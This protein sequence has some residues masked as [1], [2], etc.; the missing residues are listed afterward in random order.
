M[1]NGRLRCLGS[2][3]HLKLTFGSGYEIDMK[4]QLATTG[5]L[6]S[7]ANNLARANVIKLA[8]PGAKSSDSPLLEQ[9]IDGDEL[10]VEEMLIN[11]LI[12]KQD[13]K[14]ICSA[15]LESERVEMIA[16]NREGA[17]LYTALEAD[18]AIPLKNFLEWWIAEDY[19]CRIADFM[20]E[21]FDGATLLERS[22]TH[23]FRYRIPSEGNNLAIVFGKFED[24]KASLHLEDYSV[25]QTTLEQIFNQFAASQDNPEVE[26][27]HLQQ[28]ALRNE[29]M[30]KKSGSNHASN[31]TS[32]S[33]SSF[34]VDGKPMPLTAPPV[35]Q[36]VPFK[37]TSTNTSFSKTASLTGGIF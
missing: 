37:R 1:V 5:Q 9:G 30:N 4:S 2:S 19:A 7:I 15:L 8:T 16:P 31:S 35:S 21:T 34:G 25:G 33:R 10:H 11:T 20:R 12:N 18:G 23:S 27:E 28:Q 36:A 29:Q 17:N 13:V 22:T 6:L 3:Q 14:S 26:A 32:S 24:A